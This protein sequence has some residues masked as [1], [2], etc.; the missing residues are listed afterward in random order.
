MAARVPG[1]RNEVEY[2]IENIAELC[3]ALSDKCH[4]S[5]TAGCS[6]NH[7]VTAALLPQQVQGSSLKVNQ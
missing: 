7:M 4:Q 3:V 2:P 1:R 5:L 6:H